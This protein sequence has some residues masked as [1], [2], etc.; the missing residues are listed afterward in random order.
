MDIQSL[1]SSIQGTLGSSLPGIVGALLILIVGWFFAIAIRAGVRRGLGKV[2]LNARLGSSF[3]AE[4]FLSKV[5]FWV[6]MAFVFIGVFNAL[7]LT[8]FSEPLDAL[9]SQVT[10]YLPKGVAALIVGLVGWALA[11]GA[12]T[13]VANGLAQTS[14]DEKLAGDAGVAP[15]SSNMSNIAYWLVILLFL[16][17]VLG[18]LGLQ[19]LLAPVQ[20]M[21]DDFLAV[22]PNI[23]AAA[24]IGFVGWLVA[25]IVR[26]I[27]TNLSAS[28]G[29]DNAW[30]KAG[31]SG[32]TKLS[33]VL[34][35]V[36]FIFILVPSLIAA[37]EKLN[38]SVISDPAT[39]MLG[40]FL[41]AIPN[42]VAA[43]V[44]LTIT[45]FVARFVA[46]LLGDVLQATAFDQWPSRMGL[47][48]LA[49]SGFKLSDFAS[50]LVIFFAMLFASVE[51][52]NRLGFY[53]VRDVVTEFIQFAGQI[54]LGSVIIMVGVWLANMAAR[55]ITT[56]NAGNAHYAGIARF[57]I[58]GIVLAMGLRAMGIA[59]DIVNLAFALT[60]GAIAVAFALS[61]GL[62]GREAAGEQMSHWLR[63]MRNS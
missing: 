32:E 4:S 15:V 52:A 3:D 14:L 13:V 34:G 55:A 27:V 58:I 25:K 54:L 23:F 62:G 9:V 24:V 45:W 53:Q 28:A 31:I 40:M 2:G 48:A 39:H 7:D 19:G 38:I 10:G 49:D 42:I 56:V 59:D 12:R 33:N 41:T 18:I 5:A 30:D 61:F 26:E 35:L 63:S 60:L 11:G 6:I 1:L 47:T 57:A 20:G 21:V 51:A 36:V 8:A 44:I 17:I 22:L 46:G 29:I 37:F 50:R 43:A 16:P